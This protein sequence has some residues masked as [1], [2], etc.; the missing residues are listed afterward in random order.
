MKLEYLDDLTDGGKFKNVV[1]K[2]LI[3]LYDF[4]S[5]EVKE[6][7]DLIQN[8]IIDNGH[9]LEVSSQPFI[10]PINCNLLLRI[11]EVDNGVLKTDKGNAFVCELTKT[12][13]RT[14]IEKMKN[15]SSGYNWLCD[16]SGDDID[17]LF[18]SGGT[19]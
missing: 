12:S 5:A 19:W 1:S 11:T 10:Q 2:N 9:E 6:L 17:L 14:L 8:V 7:I 16:T 18:S 15:V 13:F 3:R 4:N